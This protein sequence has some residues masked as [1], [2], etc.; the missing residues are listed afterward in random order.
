[1]TRSLKDNQTLHRFAVF[2]TR[3]ASENIYRSVI[4]QHSRDIQV[5]SKRYSPSFQFRLP[6]GPQ[7]CT[8]GLVEG[9]RVR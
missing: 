7:P 2:L 1:M 6:V 8:E 5:L 3:F 9:T 4:N